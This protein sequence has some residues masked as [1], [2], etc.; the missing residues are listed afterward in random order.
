MKGTGTEMP[1]GNLKC[2][3]GA[4]AVYGETLNSGKTVHLCE[5][6]MPIREVKEI[7]G[8]QYGPAGQLD[9]DK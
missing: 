2:W 5:Q 3:C 7:R 1:T 9:K 6:H 8:A 4:P